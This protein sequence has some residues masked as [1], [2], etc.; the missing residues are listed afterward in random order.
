MYLYMYLQ[1]PLYL[2]IWYVCVRF[3]KQRCNFYSATRAPFKIVD[4]KSYQLLHKSEC[5]LKYQNIYHFICSLLIIQ[6]M[7]TG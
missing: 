5:V 7:A 2:F 1:H 3:L 4:A 6:Y